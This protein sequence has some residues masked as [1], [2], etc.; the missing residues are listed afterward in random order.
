MLLKN[1][2]LARIDKGALAYS[3][4]IQEYIELGFRRAVSIRRSILIHQRSL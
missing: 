4:V 2:P 1:Q 3:R